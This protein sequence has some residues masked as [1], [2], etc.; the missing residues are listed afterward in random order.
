MVSSAP[1]LHFTPSKDPVPIVQE[2]DKMD[3]SIYNIPY[4]TQKRVT[5]EVHTI[6]INDDITF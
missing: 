3:V 5:M 1:R 2:T 6:P 4:M